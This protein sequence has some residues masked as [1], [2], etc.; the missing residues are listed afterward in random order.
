MKASLTGEESAKIYKNFE[1]LRVQREKTLDCVRSGKPLNAEEKEERKIDYVQARTGIKDREKAKRVADYDESVFQA[2]TSDEASAAAR[3]IRDEEPDFED[4]YLLQVPYAAASTV[5]RVVDKTSDWKGTGFMISDE[6]FMTNFHVFRDL[7]PAQSLVEFNYELDITHSQKSVTRF[8]LAPDIFFMSSPWPDGLDF[9][10][11]AVG[12]RVGNGT[13][14]LSD[15]GFCPIRDCPNKHALGMLG[16]I[17]G[18][19]EGDC[20]KMSIRKNRIAARDDNILQYFTPTEVGSSGSPVFNS[21][22]EP[23]ALH[24]AGVPTKDLRTPDGKPIPEGTREELNEGIRISAIIRRI[25]SQ[26]NDLRNEE[27]R[28]LIEKALTCEFCYPS[29][30]HPKKK[31]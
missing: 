24:H 3:V 5:G 1:D 21:D 2:L 13:G 17:I 9:A 20:K 26:K 6:L 29:L 11:V 25:N 28:A 8:A 18:H 22:W 30:L 27:Q 31:T 4:V 19:P 7:N 14:K 23:I 16:N 15:F 10:I 12:K